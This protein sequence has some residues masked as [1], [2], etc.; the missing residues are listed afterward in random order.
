MGV[1]NTKT[2]QC[3]PHTEMRDTVGLLTHVFCRLH[4]VADMT[5]RCDHRHQQWI[6]I[7]CTL[8]LFHG[9]GSQ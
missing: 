9:T 4:A 7:F 8:S 3:S 2:L 1:I 5:Y 6:R